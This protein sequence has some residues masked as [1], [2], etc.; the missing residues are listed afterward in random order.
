[1][2]AVNVRAAFSNLEIEYRRRECDNSP[3]EKPLRR[4]NSSAKKEQHE[5]IESNGFS[6]S[7]DVVAGLESGEQAEDVG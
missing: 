7:D 6:N 4:R 2:A 1:M 5:D 3:D